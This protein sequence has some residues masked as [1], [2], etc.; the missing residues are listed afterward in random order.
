MKLC[1]APQL[2]RNCSDSLTGKFRANMNDN[3]ISGFVNHLSPLQLNYLIFS[4]LII[5]CGK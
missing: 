3:M 1:L 5:N 4:N 2:L